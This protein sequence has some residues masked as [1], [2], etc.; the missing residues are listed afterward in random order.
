MS[1]NMYV[2]NVPNK[3]DIFLHINTLQIEKFWYFDLWRTHMDI[4][5]L[6]DNEIRPCYKHSCSRN[7]N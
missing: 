6:T 7:I 5:G 4:Q 1:E 2:W 3:I